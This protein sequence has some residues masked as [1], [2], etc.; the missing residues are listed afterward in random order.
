MN[1][2]VLAL[3]WYLLIGFVIILYVLLDGYDL[4]IGILSIFYKEASDKD[5]MVSV[6]LPVWD[7]NGTWLVFGGAALYGAFPLAF[8][9]L[10]PAFYVPIILMVL[11]LLFR[12]IALEFRLKSHTS[13]KYWDWAFFAGSLL[14]TVCQ[15]VILSAFINGFKIDTTETI[16]RAWLNPL[17]YV[18]V[19]G[20]IMGYMAL[21]AD[22]LIAKTTGVLQDKFFAAS[23]K[24]Q[25]TLIVIMIIAGIL[26]PQVDPEILNKWWHSGF[27][28]ATTLMMVTLIGIFILHVIAVK[29]KNDQILFWYTVATF[30]ISFAGFIFS[31]YP[32]LV[33]HRLSFMQAAAPKSSLSFMLVGAVV[34]LPVLLIY[35]GYAYY[36]FRGKLKHP[37]GY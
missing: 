1:H 7:G 31:T 14:T 13:K 29:R 22:R 15:G 10:M 3:I 4:G 12:G 9:A 32:D 18:A 26:S 5:M 19:P 11:G 20:L 2:E 28:Y 25:Y 27:N 33:P 17:V 35:T 36:T 21:G 8:A 37:I 24:I 34:C 6:I 16:V 23:S 30:L